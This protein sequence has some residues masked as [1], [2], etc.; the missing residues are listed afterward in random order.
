M[1]DPRI[2]PIVSARHIAA[3]VGIASAVVL[4]ANP[5]RADTDLTNDGATVIYLARG[6]AAV[7]GQGIRLNPNGGS[8][9]IGTN[10]LFLGDIYGIS[11]DETSLAI[12]EGLDG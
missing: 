4:P 10:N 8:Y 6:N 3:A 9:H 7:I 12:S 11:S 1:P 5:S 2:F